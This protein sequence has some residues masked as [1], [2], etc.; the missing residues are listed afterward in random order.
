LTSGKTRVR[1]SAGL[2]APLPAT[3]RA[4]AIDEFGPPSVMRMHELEVPRP[5]SHEVLI[6]L[7]W[8]GVGSWDGSIRDG[9]WKLS[10]RPKFPLIPGVDGAGIVV[11]AGTRVR[12]VRI[13]DRVYAYESGNP[14]GGFYAP[15]ALARA[16]HVDRVPDAVDTRDAAAVVTTGL[17]ALQ[18]I[19]LLRLRRGSVVMVFGASGAVGTIAVQLAKQHGAT[20][21]ATASGRGASR[22]VRRLGADHVVDARSRDATDRIDDV[23]PEG[24]DAVLALAGGTELERVLSLVRRGGR[25]AHPNGIE[26]EPKRRAGVVVR[27]Y[28][29]VADPRRFTSLRRELEAGEVRVPIAAVFPLS[30]AA[31]AHRKMAKGHFVGRIVL[32]IPRA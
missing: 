14:Q 5:K 24:L 2:L 10:A 13:G 23:A 26:P 27:G 30:Q 18:G 20:V 25:V 17:T 32:R 21:I 11:A 9:S 22:I 16:E 7:E 28:D 15:F 31:R 3:M 6:A 1:S 12:R 29:A 4:I 8:A 19:N